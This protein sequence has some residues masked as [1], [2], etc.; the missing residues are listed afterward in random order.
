[1]WLN[2]F[3]PSMIP[4]RVDEHYEY[5]VSVSALC[6]HKTVNSKIPLL[7]QLIWDEAEPC[8]SASTCVKPRWTSPWPDLRHFK[9]A[10]ITTLRASCEHSALRFVPRTRFCKS[11]A[12]V[13][14]EA[15]VVKKKIIFHS[16]GLWSGKVIG[17][18]YHGCTLRLPKSVHSSLLQRIPTYADILFQ[19]GFPL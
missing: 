15:P 5:Y 17:K 3:L 7:P 19:G 18:E 14:T 11:V 9:A 10:S 16:Y 2:N 1:M 6:F 13:T 8:F 4:V 12:E